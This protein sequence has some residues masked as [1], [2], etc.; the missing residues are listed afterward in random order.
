ML[1]S[2][3]STKKCIP[4][5]LNAVTSFFG[6]RLYLEQKDP[7]LTNEQTLREW[8]VLAGN[9]DQAAF[10]RLLR[11]FWNKVYTQALVYLK[12][13]AAAQ[14]VTQDVFLKVWAKRAGLP[15]V[16]NF[17]GYLFIITRNEIVNALRKKGREPAAPSEGLEENLWIPDQQLQFKESY[18][19]LLSG[20]EALPPARKNVFKLSRL[21]GLS[22]EEIGER[23]GIS[24]NSVKDHIVRSLVFLRNYLR[25][26]TGETLILL[27]LLAEL[28]FS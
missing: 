17:P 26:H 20:I 8:L 4:K 28:A 21:E 15:Q 24:R 19:L 5:T 2:M 9:D 13:S 25:T 10:T 11:H 3:S 18:Q 7:Y 22:Y 27:W 12:S 14:E 23:L 6:T 1:R 16:D